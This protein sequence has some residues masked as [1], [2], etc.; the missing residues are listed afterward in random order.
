MIH[1]FNLSSVSVFSKSMKDG[2]ELRSAASL[3]C[4]KKTQVS[5]IDEHL[6]IPLCLTFGF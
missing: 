2:N 4:S 3:M 6:F 5:D 1:D